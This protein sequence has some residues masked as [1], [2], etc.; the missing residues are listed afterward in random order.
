MNLSS[1]HGAAAG[2]LLDSVVQEI[3]VKTGLVM[4]EWHALG[5]IAAGESNNPPQT[6]SYPWDYA[7][8][9]SVDPGPA[10]DVLL[11]AR[12]T[13]ALYDVDI[14]TGAMRW[15]LGGSRSS[16]KLGPGVRFYWQHDGEFQPGG[17]IS[18]F[19]NGSDPPKEKQSRGLLLLPDPN[20]RTVALVRQF[21]NQANLPT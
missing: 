20:T 13:W 18:L 11:S 2:I 10:G 17:Q 14:R 7:H 8:V 12:N 1:V 21:V 16:F 19:D 5:H 3:D 15:R 6:Y 9:N 4:W